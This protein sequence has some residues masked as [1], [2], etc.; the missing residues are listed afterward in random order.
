M[1]IA[2]L[3]HITK[4]E[5]FS[6]ENIFLRWPCCLSPAKTSHSED[7]CNPLEKTSCSLRT[8]APSFQARPP[9]YYNK[10]SYDCPTIVINRINPR[11][12]WSLPLVL[13]PLPDVLIPV[14]DASVHLALQ[15]QALRFAWHSGR[16]CSPSDSDH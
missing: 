15:V 2:Y 10:E 16:Y 5:E 12:M 13:L 4:K 14:C 8:T 7:S 11:Q 3:F 9:R 6:K 1:V